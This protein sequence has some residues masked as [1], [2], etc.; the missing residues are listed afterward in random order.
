MTRPRPPRWDPESLADTLDVVAA[1]LCA[2]LP[3]EY[4]LALARDSTAW[5][6]REAERLEHVAARLRHGEPTASAWA[7]SS[8]E[9][10]AADAFHTVGHVW[11]LALRTGGPLAEAV[12]ALSDHLREEARLQGRLL[13]LAAAPRTSARL[14]SLLP[15]VGPALALLIGAHPADLYLSS[16]V[17]GASALV[18]LLLTAVGWR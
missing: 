3:P 7:R 8:D 13:A 6:R 12:R 5:G 16:P 15:L 10:A 9:R 18:G 1:G 14:L 2:G 4:A 17:A 11:D